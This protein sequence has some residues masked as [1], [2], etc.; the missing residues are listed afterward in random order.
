[1]GFE[2]TFYPILD[3]Y[4]HDIT[5]SGDVTFTGTVTTQS[6]TAIEGAVTIDVTDNEALLIRQDSDGGDIFTVN[7]TTGDI[8][9]GSSAQDTGTI[10]MIKGAQT[11][12]PQ[13]QISLSA[14]ANG[15]VTFVS[16]TGSIA[17]QMSADTNDYITFDTVSNVPCIF[18]TGAY[19]SIGDAG[20]TSNSLDSED[21]LYISG[22][23]ECGS[24]LYTGSIVF[25]EDSG[26]VTA[27][28]MPVSATPADGTVEGYSFAVDGT[29]I[30]TIYSEA[31]S[32]GAVDN[33]RVGINTITPTAALD[34]R[35]EGTTDILNLYETGGTE[36]MTVLESG[37]VGI[38]TTAPESS[39]H[40]RS[41]APYLTLDD[42]SNTGTKPYGRILLGAYLSKSG[43]D[44]QL[45][46]NQAGL[47]S[48]MVMNEDCNVGIGTTSPDTLLELSKD[49]A[50]TE[51][52]ISTYHDTEAT[53]PLI[54]LR[55]AD[56][57]ESSPA[58]VDDNAVLGTIKF[59]GYDGSGFEDGAYI[60]ARVD[61][62]PS[63]GTDMPTE[64]V[65]AVSADASST[66][67]EVLFLDP[68]G[69]AGIGI[70]PT[71]NMTGLVLEGGALT[72]KE[73]TTPTADTDYGKIYTKTDN[74]AYF[75]DGAGVEHVIAHTD[76][77]YGEF[78]WNANGTATTIET[79]NTPI[80]LRQTTTGLV[81]GWTYNAGSTG[82]ITA[83]ANYS[84]T[85]EGT[86]LVTSGTHGLATG[87]EIS[88][89]GTTNY[90]GVF[91]VTYVSADTFYITDTWVDDN[92]ASDWDEGS[93]LEA[94][95][96]AAGK[97]VMGYSVS[98]TEAGGAGSDWI[99]GLYKNSTACPKC[100]SKRKLANNDYGSISSHSIMTIAEGD[101][102]YLT[103]SST[104]TNTL[105]VQYGDLSLHRL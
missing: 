72:L 56:N 88:I 71:A 82:A 46:A 77:N 26:L 19:L 70:T 9:L 36:V 30:L 89:R 28:D 15:D 91:T 99:I 39:L 62:T 24:N 73:I 41:S 47:S 7:T 83:Y 16:D 37:N 61:G 12:D 42:S 17:F 84:E 4:T 45:G 40:I 20:T 58:L 51:L 6:T 5:F 35:T 3:T 103:A 68:A 38:G 96:G 27:F 85:V 43:F 55:K 32:A 94:G 80:M 25:A 23:T 13:L 79:A 49:S 31:D 50:D 34:I 11:G 57:T 52:T 18:G 65:F 53:T 93:Y 22:E 44:F 29:D 33:K 64:L 86:V 67:T 21:D 102:V 105:T 10:T 1:M 63:D 66:P 69:N 87:D 90:N 100:V 76:T 74:R 60:Q 59:Q 104:G 81:N 78:Y 54:T 75:Q 97:Y 98:V 14:D 8:T 2:T 95:T 101:R 48:V 92:G